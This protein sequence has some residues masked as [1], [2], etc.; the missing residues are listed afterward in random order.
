MVLKRND[1]RNSSREYCVEVGRSFADRGDVI[2]SIDAGI[3]FVCWWHNAKSAKVSGK[4]KDM[5]SSTKFAFKYGA[6]SQ[7]IKTFTSCTK[8]CYI[9]TTGCR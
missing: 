3:S 7:F 2:T 4:H 5:N 6:C 8:K 1:W 9:H